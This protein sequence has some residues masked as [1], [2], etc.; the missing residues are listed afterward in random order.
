[1]RV[2]QTTGRVRR[3]PGQALRAVFTGIGQMFLAADRLKE[4]VESAADAKSGDGTAGGWS[5]ESVR[6][7]GG[8]AAPGQT[9]PGKT[10]PGKTAG[11]ADRSR[12]SASAGAGTAAQSRWRSL[13]TTGNVRLLS[14]EDLALEFPET[15][16]APAKP[17]MSVR[18]ET[19][20]QTLIVGQSPTL[21]RP[22]VAHHAVD[23]EETADDR[24]ASD[25]V[26]ETAPAPAPIAPAS[27]EPPRTIVIVDESLARYE[28]EQAASEQAATEQAAT[29]QAA[30][31]EWAAAADADD[32]AVAAEP[33][34]SAP[35]SPRDLIVIVD[36][37]AYDD[38]AL[39]AGV[40]A[41]TPAAAG[42]ADETTVLDRPV[43]PPD[44]DTLPVPSYD[45]LSLPSLRARLRNLDIDQ[46]RMLVEYERAN[47]ARADVITMFERRIDKLAA[48]Q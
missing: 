33:N 17:D 31:D 24:S 12:R 2:P 38:T 47:A 27:E 39:D 9:A 29:E 4:Q 18:P 10:A 45:S 36:D 37:T 26:T 30:T 32:D 35:A 19:P 11:R 40:S 22:P 1:M 46:V 16:T 7:A 43:P 25:E 13:D 15:P 34:T 14:A 42:T 21:D 5:H 20:R 41:E 6:V 48:S 44:A 3:G 8:K 28:A 23:D